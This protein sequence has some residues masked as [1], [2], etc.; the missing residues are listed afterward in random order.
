MQKN[1]LIRAFNKLKRLRLYDSDHLYKHY[2]VQ[3][4]KRLL[5]EFDVDCVFDV[6]ANRGQY[7]QMLRQEANFA[8]R[9]ISFEPSPDIA[10]HIAARAAGYP[11]WSVEK[12]ALS[13]KDGEQT[14]LI[15]KGDEFSSLSDPS[16]EGTAYIGKNNKPVKKA[17]V[18]TQ[19]LSSAYNRL[20]SKYG[21]KR[22]FLKMDTQGYD[23][24]VATSGKDIIGEFVG[25]QS[26]LSVMP[27]YK[28]SVLYADAIAAYEELG[29]QLSAFAPNNAG[30]FPVLVETDCIMFNKKLRETMK[31]SL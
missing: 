15:M 10:D 18:Q 11:K 20:K 30:H 5:H 9:I 24:I 6:G 17:T 21:F 28:D 23:V 12:I 14:F 26:E 25:L 22:P 8:G 2:E 4:L 27:L 29:F 19:T 7:A 16:N 1:I 13:D 3:H 31:L